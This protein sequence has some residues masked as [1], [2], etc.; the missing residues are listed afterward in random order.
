MNGLMHN[1]LTPQG[2]MSFFISKSGF[3][4]AW[5]RCNK[6][7]WLEANMSEQKAPVD[8]FTQSLFDNGHKIGEIA[9]KYFCVDVDVTVNKEDGTPNLA[10][11]LRQTEK[12]MQLG[13]KVIAEASFRYDGCFCSV[14]V[15]VRNAD[16]SYDILE[17]KSSKQ[18]KP[19]KKNPLGVKE[20]YM[21]DAAYQRYVLENCGVKVNCVYVVM[22]AKD[23]VRGTTLD[24]NQYFVKIDVTDETAA[25][26]NDVAIKIA[27]LKPVL[28]STNEPTSVICGNC[29]KC[30]YFG[31]CGRNIPSPSPFDV[32]DLDFPVK[33]Q[34]YNDGVSFFDIPKMNLKLKA[35]AKLQIEYYNRPGDLYIDKT[36][37]NAFLNSITWPAYSLD[38]ETYQAVLPEFEGVKTY[39]QLPFQYSLHIIKSAECDCLEERH[40]LD[41]TGNDSRRDIAE[42]LVQNIPYGACVVAYHHG[43]E[44]GIIE[45]LANACPDLK[46]HLL[47][48][49]YRD[50]LEVFQKGYYYVKA[51]GGS[52]SLKSTAPALYPNEKSMDY[53]NLEGDVKN[54]VQA[55][56][57]IGKSKDMTAE[58]VEKLRCDLLAYCAQDTMGVVKIL[59]KFYEDAM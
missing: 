33:C 14:D 1:N 18:E 59:K 42:S 55:M 35:P 48:F 2:H 43:T 10:E 19:T 9:K 21:M 51:M 36:A 53:H 11:M 28:T 45:R 20:K 16:G 50:P 44:K 27:E 15:L 58:E 22:L 46:D 25:R 52:L 29:N 47:S 49:T 32:Y 17:V 13:T 23:Y 24:L 7:A 40:F 30:E 39:E 41:I 4:S 31:Y 56:N 26:Q 12:Y 34:Y 57:A 37:V 3:V 54:G 6:Y 8:E 38:F 5:R